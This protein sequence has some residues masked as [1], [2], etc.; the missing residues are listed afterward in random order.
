MPA[1]VRAASTIVVVVPESAVPLTSERIS[2][3]ASE[4]MLAAVM[5]L[6]AK[7]LTVVTFVVVVI[8]PAVILVVLAIVP[9]GNVAARKPAGCV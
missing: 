4:A 6:A 7:P 2:V 3:E 9:L 1:S 8:V 5:T